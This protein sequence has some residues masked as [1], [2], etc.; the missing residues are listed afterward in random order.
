[1]HAYL[2]ITETLKGVVAV[3]LNILPPAPTTWQISGANT[4]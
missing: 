1:M 3:I 2:Y 4:L